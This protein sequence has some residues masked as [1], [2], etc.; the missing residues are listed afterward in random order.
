MRA[1][2]STTSQP[3]H[4]APHQRARERAEANLTGE[5]RA[6][7]M[8]MGPPHVAVVAQ[9]T[10][11]KDS[12]TMALALVA[13]TP[14]LFPFAFFFVFFGQGRVGIWVAQLS[15]GVGI[16]LGQVG[17]GRRGCCARTPLPL[18]ILPRGST[19]LSPPCSSFLRT[20]IYTS[21]RLKSGHTPTQYT[22][23]GGHLHRHSPSVPKMQAAGARTD[24][25]DLNA[26]FFGSWRQNSWPACQP[27]N[28]RFDIGLVA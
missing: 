18:P 22:W 14:F 15:R 10:R 19:L 16:H 21:T 27:A 6:Q 25:R 7:S 8:H 2:F 11:L 1:G 5:G 28:A 17:N 23:P 3:K 20:Y 9:Q 12:G 13:S 24:R 26:P 4:P